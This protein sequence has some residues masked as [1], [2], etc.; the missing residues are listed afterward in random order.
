MRICYVPKA[1][2]D[3][4][5]EV[6]DVARGICESYAADGYDLTLRQLYYQ[7]VSRALIPNTL[8]SY[9]RLGGILNDARLAGEIDWDH[10]TDRTRSLESLAHWGSASEIVDA[11]AR[12]FRTERWSTQ[13][14]RVEVWI[15]KEALAGV[16]AVACEP[17]DVDYFSCRG[18]TSQSELWAAG[19]RIGRYLDAGQDVTILHLGD[20]DPSGL[21]MTRDIRDRLAIFL[22]GDGHDTHRLDVNRIALNYDQVEQYDPP[23]NPAKFTDSRA[24]GYVARYGESSWEL[25]ALDP[26]TLVALIQSNVEALRDEPLWEQATAEQEEHRENLTAASDRWDDVVDYLTP[27]EELDS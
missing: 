6:I 21:D 23:P 5:Q 10:V 19:Q 13:P 1:F 2:T 20:H 8:Q 3:E 26:A 25:D 22:D 7:F 9:K 14:N 18:Y 4:H 12:Q 27:E 15:E 16:A 17:L 11:V 24:R